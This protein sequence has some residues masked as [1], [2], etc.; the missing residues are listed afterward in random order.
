MLF[1]Y[2]TTNERKSQSV[3]AKTYSRR[4]L[5]KNVKRNFQAEGKAP[6]L[7][8]V[9]ELSYFRGTIAD[10]VGAVLPHLC[11]RR[12]F[13]VFTPGATVA[14]R[15]LTDGELLTL[16]RRADLLLPDGK[17]VTL[18]SRLS[19]AGHLP[20]IAGIDFA[21]ALFAASAFMETRVFLY[22]GAAGVAERAAAALRA[23][24]PHLIIAV[25][26]GFGEDPSERISAFL[27]HVVCVCL[28]AGKQEAWID[29]NKASVGGVLL[30]LGGSLDV[31][32]GDLRRAPRLLRRMGF[33]W[34][35]RTV[36]EPKRVLRLFPL[37][38]YFLRCLAVRQNSK[39]RNE[40]SG[41]V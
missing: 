38:R 6:F 41:A 37:P 4:C 16:L 33:E 25:S 5:E 27:P 30:G 18:A 34:A 15:A 11:S 40:K 2:F 39:K 12:P 1:F 26:D 29:E 35:W 22:G 23:R 24:Y 19:G 14:A 13:A 36:R 20:S 28:G 17:G 8:E 3:L 32:S 10:A 21:E 7:C 9:L 31:W